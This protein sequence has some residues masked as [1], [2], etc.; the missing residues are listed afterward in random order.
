[1]LVC[2]DN[3]GSTDLYGFVVNCMIL[4]HYQFVVMGKTQFDFGL[5]F[6]GKVIANTLSPRALPI[7][8]SRFLTVDNR[9]HGFITSLVFD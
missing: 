4:S 2:G 5:S 3:I 9:I 7:S 8:T 6:F 1:M